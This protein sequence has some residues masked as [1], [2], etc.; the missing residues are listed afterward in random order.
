V[1]AFGSIYA[2]ATPSLNLPS[3]ILE[4]TDGTGLDLPL[5]INA[6]VSNNNK[7]VELPGTTNSLTGAIT[8]ATGL[9]KVNFRPT[10]LGKITRASTGVVLQ[11][12]NI[13]YGAFI[14]NDDG[15][16]KTNTGA[17]YLH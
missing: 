7:I 1:D 17:I 14:G 5:F 11:S 12:S 10:G 4:I 16:G 2:P 9:L 6:G 13:A 8:A 15:T 3:G